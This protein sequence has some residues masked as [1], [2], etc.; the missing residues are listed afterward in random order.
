VHYPVV[1]RLV[2]L[3]EGAG[4]QA[5]ALGAVLAPLAESRA[6]AFSRPLFSDESKLRAGGAPP[7]AEAL[8]V[9]FAAIDRAALGRELGIE[10]NVLDTALNRVGRALGGGEEEPEAVEGERVE[11]GVREL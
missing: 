2:G 5:R 8:R 10:R 6:W 4:E 1:A 11:R 3:L 7:G 9:A